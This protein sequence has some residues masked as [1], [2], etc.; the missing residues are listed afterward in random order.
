MC[1]RIALP[2]GGFAIV[3]GGRH[4]RARCEEC[5]RLGRRTPAD[6]EC[7]GPPR[8]PG[9]TT[10]DRKCCRAH[11]KRIGPDRDLCIECARAEA[12]GTVIKTLWE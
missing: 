1:E 3:C 10:C 6:I 11:A 8:R 7:D 12:K 4:T 9:A 2:G 5:A